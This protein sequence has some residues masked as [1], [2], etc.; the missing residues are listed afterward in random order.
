MGV[1]LSKPCNIAKLQFDI[2]FTFSKRMAIL[3]ISILLC[4]SFWKQN[5]HHQTLNCFV[6]IFCCCC[7]LKRE[8]AMPF[9]LFLNCD[10]NKTQNIEVSI[11]HLV[12]I[13]KVSWFQNVLLVSK[14]LP[15]NQRNYFWI[16]ALIFFAPSWGLPGSFLS[17]L[18]T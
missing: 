14:L 12:P 6:L 2:K 9:L 17:F 11:V 18:G 1:L 3:P 4:I 13:L 15:K 8:E 5:L 7:N 10:N 16:S